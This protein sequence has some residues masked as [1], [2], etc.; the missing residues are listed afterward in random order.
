LTATAAAA[1]VDAAAETA[2]WL[3]DATLENQ[4]DQV[5]KTT[6][7]IESWTGVGVAASQSPN[8]TNCCSYS[9]LSC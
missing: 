1:V 7:S 9:G 3:I 2:S 6:R 5:A 8:S 4:R